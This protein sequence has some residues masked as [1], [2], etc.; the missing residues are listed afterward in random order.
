M[1]ERFDRT[2]VG[3]IVATDAAGREVQLA[4]A[5]GVVKN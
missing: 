3:E 5:P 2:T 4:I 1:S